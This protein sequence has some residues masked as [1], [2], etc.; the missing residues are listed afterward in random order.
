MAK[1]DDFDD[2]NKLAGLEID[3]WQALVTFGRLSCIFTEDF[4]IAGADSNKLSQ[5]FGC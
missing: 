2:S 5:N 1:C 4:W 3:G